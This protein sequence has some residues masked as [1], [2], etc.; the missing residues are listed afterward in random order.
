[1]V[2]FG[3]R[4][5]VSAAYANLHAAFVP[6]F[7]TGTISLFNGQYVLLQIFCS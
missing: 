2:Q 7:V 5:L 6:F 4:L 1:M 3:P